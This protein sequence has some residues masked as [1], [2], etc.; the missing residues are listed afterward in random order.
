MFTRHF[1]VIIF[2]LTFVFSSAFSGVHI[3]VN[4]AE[5]L[6]FMNYWSN[7]MEKIQ[8]DCTRGLRWRS[9]F[10]YGAALVTT[11][12]VVILYCTEKLLPFEETAGFITQSCLFHVRDLYTYGSKSGVLTVLKYMNQADLC[13]ECKD[14]S[15]SKIGNETFCMEKCWNVYNRP[16]HEYEAMK[17][18]SS[19]VLVSKR[20]MKELRDFLGMSKIMKWLIVV[21]LSKL[22]GV[23][24][25]LHVFLSVTY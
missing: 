16:S 15:G 5:I 11:V 14:C 21:L 18:V 1:D 22:F 3:W 7:M 9:V 10:I 17:A 2:F 23:P 24:C 25:A 6:H 19:I 13:W 8:I 4:K 12:L 20:S